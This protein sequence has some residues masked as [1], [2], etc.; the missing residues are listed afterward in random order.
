MNPPK[1]ICDVEINLYVFYKLNAY[2]KV[3]ER[4]TT[5]KDIEVFY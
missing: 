5:V 1:N 3:I 4:R 2:K